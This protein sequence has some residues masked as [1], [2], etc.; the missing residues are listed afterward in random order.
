MKNIK[1]VAV[2]CCSILC[3]ALILAGVY[4]TSIVEVVAYTA[5]ETF[6]NHDISTEYQNDTLDTIDDVF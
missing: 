5:A 3:S 1:F 2:L 4:C 6:T